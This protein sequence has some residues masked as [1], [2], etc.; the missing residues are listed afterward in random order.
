I[1][2]W[3]Y[4]HVLSSSKDRY[5][6]IR[7]TQLF[8]TDLA[9]EHGPPP[10]LPL[11]SGTSV[12]Q[13]RSDIEKIRKVH[14]YILD[15]LHE[16]LPSLGTLARRFLVNEYKLKKGFKALYHTTIFKFHLAKRL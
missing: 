8:V 6:F 1:E 9:T 11:K 16:P 12:L 13:L 10:A 14:Q 15:H 2:S 7:G 3:G 5:Y 4:C